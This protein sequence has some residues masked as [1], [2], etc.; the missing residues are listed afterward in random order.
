VPITDLPPLRSALIWR[1]GNTDPRRR[2]FVRIARDVL[3]RTARRG[4]D[5]AG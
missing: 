1:R 5:P 4:A 2:E 3:G